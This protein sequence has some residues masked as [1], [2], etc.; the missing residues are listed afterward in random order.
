MVLKF[1]SYKANEYEKISTFEREREKLGRDEAVDPVLDN[2]VLGPHSWGG[3]GAVR[4]S[5]GGVSNQVGDTIIWVSDD[6]WTARI[7]HASAVDAVSSDALHTIGD[8]AWS[9]VSFAVFSR[10][11]V[12]FSKWKLGWE[13]FDVWVGHSPSGDDSIHTTWVFFGGNWDDSDIWVS[14]IKLEFHCG[15]QVNC[16][17]MLI[18]G[19]LV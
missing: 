1:Y 5:E 16:P 3:S 7:S 4:G 14:D 9:P 6:K 2:N 11:H 8:S 17:K 15:W 18:F 12:S 10:Y 19:W 13:S